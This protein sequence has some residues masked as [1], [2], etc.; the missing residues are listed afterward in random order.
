MQNNTNNRSASRSVKD[1]KKMEERERVVD[2][3][4]DVVE[5]FNELDD[6]DDLNN[7]D[8]L[9]ETDE[10][11]SENRDTEKK[12]T[13]EA[14]A[15]RL[16]KMPNRIREIYR[17]ANISTCFDIFLFTLKKRCEGE[18]TNIYENMWTNNT[19]RLCSRFKNNNLTEH[20]DQYSV[21]EEFVEYMTNTPVLEIL[22]TF[23]DISQTNGYNA[24]L[25]LDAL[26]DTDGSTNKEIDQ[27]SQYLY[28]CKDIYHNFVNYIAIVR[29]LG[30]Q[31]KRIFHEKM[32]LIILGSTK[33]III[34]IITIMNHASQQF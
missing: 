28:K 1:D 9:S 4:G 5:E 19:Y 34:T 21:P 30:I 31:I 2:E 16:E 8:N 27:A 33:I 3:I 10:I 15:Q 20:T 17:N 32:N 6:L 13:P 23:N 7:I 11:E 29:E 14:T 25:K 24:K 26:Q 18:F 22:Q 12:F